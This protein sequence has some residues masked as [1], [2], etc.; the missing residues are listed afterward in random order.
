MTRIQNVK[1]GDPMGFKVNV[2]S[3]SDEVVLSS[4]VASL[5]TYHGGQYVMGLDTMY[6]DKKHW[7]I[8]WFAK[9]EVTANALKV[10]RNSLK[11]K[12]DCLGKAD[13]LYTGQDL[14]SADKDYWIAYA[15]KE[16]NEPHGIWSTTDIEITPRIKTLA[17]S[18]LESKRQKK[19]ISEKKANEEKDKLDER[20]KMYAY[21]IQNL[22]DYQSIGSDYYGDEQMAF[23]CT[24]IKYK[25]TQ[26]KFGCIKKHF[27]AQ[28]YLEYKCHYAQEKWNELQVY[29][30]I[31]NK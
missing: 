11:K 9:K 3:I 12:Y 8:H 22:P 1:V 2:E 14:P 18:I 25:M 15:I 10:F 5:S 19:V 4:L 26:S 31:H 6:C 7:H 13:K 21:V 20:E 29:K 24:V 17:A 28:Y 16:M 27:L 23:E 30:Y